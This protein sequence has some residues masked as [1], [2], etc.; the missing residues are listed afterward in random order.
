MEYI[1]GAW[2]FVKMAEKEAGCPEKILCPCKDCRNL[3]HQSID[4]VFAH[5]VISGMDQNIHRVVSSWGT[6]LYK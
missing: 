1:E 3:C 2:N 4:S 6:K 5:L